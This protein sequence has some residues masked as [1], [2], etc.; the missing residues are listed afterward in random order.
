MILFTMKEKLLTPLN[1]R[2]R[3]AVQITKGPL[4]I[5]AGAGSGKTKCLT[6]R[7]G[8][9]MLEGIPGDKILAVTFTNKAAN[10]MKSR[11]ESLVAPDLSTRMPTVGTFHATCVRILRQH[12]EHLGSGLTK[13]F[14]IFDSAD[15][16]NL[17]RQLIKDNGFGEDI[18]YR[19]VLSH[20]SSAKNQL[21]SPE[22]YE[23][24]TEDNRFTRAVKVLYRHYQRKL[25]DHNA[26]DFDDLLQKTV[27]LFETSQETLQYYRN[28]WNHLMIDEYQDT[29]FAQYRLVRLL[30]DE[31]KNICVIG[32]DHQSIYSFRG[33]DYTNILNFEKDFP[34]ANIVKLEQNYR[35]TQNILKNANC[36][37]NHNNTGLKKTLWTQNEPGE[38]VTLIQVANERD[39][40]N[41]IAEKIQQLK[42]EKKALSRDCAILYRMNAQSR[43]IEEALM[44]AQIPYQIIGGTKFFDRKEIK[45]IIA[46]LRL[47]FNIRD[48]VSFTRILNV[49]ARKI[50]PASFE[51]LRKY[52]MEKGCSLFEAA[53]D[54]A[55]NYNLSPR[56][57]RTI[58]DFVALIQDLRK[59]SESEPVTNIIDALV[60][61]THYEQWL[62]DGTAEGEARIQ[63]VQE[64]LSVANK[65]DHADDSLASFLEGV[66]LI[67]DIDNYEDEND[68]VT[69]MTVHASKG[70][71]FPIIFLPGWEEGMFPSAS[72]ATDPAQMEEERRLGYVAITRAERKCYILNT[73][74]RMLFGRRQYS[75]PSPFID[76]LENSAIEH[77]TTLQQSSLSRQSF[78]G[79]STQ[80]YTR[81]S[82]SKE[83]PQ[84][85]STAPKNRKEALWGITEN[86]SLFKSGQKITHKE[87]GEGTIILV[88]G[89]VLSVAF[90]GLGVKK[91]VGSVAPIDIVE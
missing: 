34:D 58:L 11:I 36:L 27:Q 55:A 54:C 81:S 38:K 41:V 16:K 49:P 88:S 84:F 59:I 72:A 76:E 53:C 91:I 47:I 46:Y 42:Q 77:D 23:H 5:L 75:S 7:T 14:V 13:S 87:Y 24:E 67:A 35:S 6:H 60:K 22:Q 19:A 44:R 74:E 9:L 26:L 12:I 52:S 17:M 51:A 89:D 80:S 25:L 65:Y 10:E 73:R 15:S 1:E 64:I 86:V 43:A 66:A 32:D 68:T 50:G 63:N 20:I 4:L 45:D 48:D 40:G 31:H 30:S 71:E 8:Y 28:K 18:K 33:A 21:L 61:K 69:L 82:S 79:H 83:R 37:I 62:N 70:L 85:L 78:L 3:E 2:Q 90:K 29:N 56:K 57:Q 39:E